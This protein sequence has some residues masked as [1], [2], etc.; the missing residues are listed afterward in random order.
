MMVGSGARALI[1]IVNIVFSL[2]I[3]A[4]YLRIILQHQRADYYN[5]AVQFIAR[6]TDPVVRPLRRL[7]P[8]VAGWDIAAFLVAIVC[9]FIN[10][11]IVHYLIGI[12]LAGPLLARD[13]GMKLLAVLLN[14]YIFTIL[15]QALM[16]WINPGRYS[17]VAALLWRMNE[18][19]L[20]PVR[21][22]I[23]PLGGTFDL[24]P[25][26]VIVILEALSIF[27]GLPGYL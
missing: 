18:P 17:P 8:G 11:V 25:L 21:R 27:L 3:A 20:R 1:F 14:L 12:G 15:I 10:V 19:L 23:P 13:T 7:I 9:G 16:S 4:L 5:P 2:Y 24:S 26:I 6:V 22:L